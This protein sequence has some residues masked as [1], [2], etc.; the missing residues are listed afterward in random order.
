[1]SA[2]SWTPSGDKRKHSLDADGLDADGETMD[3]SRGGFSYG[4]I[5]GVD[6]GQ[7]TV[8]GIDLPMRLDE[9]RI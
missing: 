5:Y 9:K 7:K 8:K 4:V 6:S 2:I 3:I 1:M